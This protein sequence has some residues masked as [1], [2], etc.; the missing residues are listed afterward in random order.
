M[1][2]PQL[3][4]LE[5]LSLCSLYLA[6]RLFS[7]QQVP[8]S[9]GLKLSSCSCPG[10]D[11]DEGTA[12]GLWAVPRKEP[13]PGQGRGRH[14]GPP[15]GAGGQLSVPLSWGLQIG[16]LEAVD[17]VLMMHINGFNSSCALQQEGLCP[18]RCLRL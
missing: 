15:L 13:C 9:K 16:F 7:L 18:S 11:G 8:E 5:Q 12:P 2:Y 1:R 6:L 10:R 17:T 4:E 3:V 14:L